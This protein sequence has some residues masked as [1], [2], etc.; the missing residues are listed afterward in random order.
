MY[1][2]EAYSWS[3]AGSTMAHA[4]V[5]RCPAT[6]SQLTNTRPQAVVLGSPR[7]QEQGVICAQMIARH[8]AEP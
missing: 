3:A 7:E 2:A 8:S 5:V 6:Q 4:C 1:R